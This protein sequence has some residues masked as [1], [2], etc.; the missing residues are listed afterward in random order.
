[1]VKTW[2]AF[3]FLGALGDCIICFHYWVGSEW[4]AKAERANQLEC[5]KK[6]AERERE[7]ALR[8]CHRVSKKHRDIQSF[9]VQFEW[10]NREIH[11][12][13]VREWNREIHSGVLLEFLS[14]ITME[15]SSIQRKILLLVLW[16]NCIYSLRFI[17][18][19]SNLLWTQV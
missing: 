16:W 5:E 6:H 10:R 1:M 8:E 18:C 7:R 17:C 15:S 2:G 19:I 9:E 12:E 13:S 4:R 11:S 14:A 3:F